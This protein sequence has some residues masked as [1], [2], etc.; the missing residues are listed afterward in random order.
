MLE[1]FHATASGSNP[2]PELASRQRD[3]R[4]GV[5]VLFTEDSPVGGE[6]EALTVERDIGKPHGPG[7]IG[8][9]LAFAS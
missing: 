9:T 4:Q 7:G 8:R 6:V 1:S 3:Q 5:A 2:A